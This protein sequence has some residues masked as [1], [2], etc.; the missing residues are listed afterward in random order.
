MAPLRFLAVVSSRPLAF[1]MIVNY[2]KRPLIAK[3]MIQL[4]CATIDYP[5]YPVVYPIRRTK[6]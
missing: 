2:T 3:S 1:E 5:M 6:L 4:L